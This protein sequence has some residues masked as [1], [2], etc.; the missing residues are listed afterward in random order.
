MG[1]PEIVKCSLVNQAS[2]GYPG[3][4]FGNVI[5]IPHFGTVTL[6]Q[7][8]VVHECFKEGTNVPE[9]TTVQLRILGP[10]GS[11]ASSRPCGGVMFIRITSK[12][13]WPCS[14][15]RASIAGAFSPDSDAI[16]NSTGWGWEAS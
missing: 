16:I 12:I 3:S 4:T 6:A 15:K 8:T 11:M 2:G 14:R 5:R 1:A 13:R 7:L 9:K 10:S